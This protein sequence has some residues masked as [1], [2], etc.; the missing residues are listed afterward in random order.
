MKKA[1]KKTKAEAKAQKA[2][3]AEELD[4]KFDAGEDMSEYLDMEKATKF[5]NVEFPLWMVKALDDEAERLSVPR[6][7]I[8]KMWIDERLKRRAAGET[9]RQELEELEFKM[10][11]DQKRLNDLRARLES[12]MEQF[13]PPK[14]KAGDDVAS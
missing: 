4:A 9:L 2:I 1:A 3:S 13:T 12:K 14:R 8:I 7:A 10:Q 11:A 5:V 6:Q